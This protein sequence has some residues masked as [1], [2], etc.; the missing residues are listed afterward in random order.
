MMEIRKKMNNIIETV[1]SKLIIFRAKW[2]IRRKNGK[3]ISCSYRQKYFITA[4]AGQIIKMT[5]I[6]PCRLVVS[7]KR[8]AHEITQELFNYYYK[9][10]GNVPGG[11]VDVSFI[12]NLIIS[13]HELFNYRGRKID[14]VIDNSCILSKEEL[15]M[16]L[17][18]PCI[19]LCGGIMYIPKE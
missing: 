5:M 8:Q 9:I 16:I 1:N 2:N 3:I 6:N 11:I 15:S 17:S 4:L 7:T 14:V 12:S 18:N 10:R 13:K 19:K